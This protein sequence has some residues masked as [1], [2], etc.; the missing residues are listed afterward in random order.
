M[1]LRE[2]F[3]LLGV[4]VDE[5]N[6]GKAEKL[7]KDLNKTA[8]KSSRDFGKVAKAYG[9]ATLK[10]GALAAG[11]AYAG[12]K[13]AQ[14]GADAIETR[15]LIGIAFGEGGDAFIK[16]TEDL[17]RGTNRSKF[18][19]QEFGAVLQDQLVGSLQDMEAAS[20]MT[21]TLLERAVDISSAKNVAL[22]DVLIKIKSGLTGETQ[23]LRSLGI[24]VG[25]DSIEAFAKTLGDKRKI[26]DMDIMSKVMLRQK[27]IMFDT[28]RLAGDAVKTSGALANQMVGLRSATRDAAT[29][30]SANLSPGFNQLTKAIRANVERTTEWLKVN[31]EVI[32]SKFLEYMDHLTDAYKG[33]NTIMGEMVSSLVALSASLGDTESAFLKLATLVGIIALAFWSPIIAIGLLGALLLSIA[34]D[35]QKF[36]DGHKSAIGYILSQYPNAI[37][38]FQTM[39]SLVEFGIDV[40]EWLGL[41][42]VSVFKG[43]FK[44]VDQILLIFK[45]FMNAMMTSYTFITDIFTKGIETAFTSL[46]D[47]ILYMF[48]EL[49]GVDISG[50]VK[51]S[52]RSLGKF[53]GLGKKQ[54]EATFVMD[55]VRPP[56]NVSPAVFARNG[57]GTG[58]RNHVEQ[59][60]TNSISVTAAP[61]EAK[62]VGDA[63]HKRL[64]GGFRMDLDQTMLDF[65]YGE[66]VG[67]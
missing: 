1:I 50:F 57:G 45:F 59:T 40:V 64:S 54:M 39:W 48:D 27:K 28:E 7:L 3:V 35:V 61:G 22:A 51:E 12:V 9:T 11:A 24:E 38:L 53:F 26:R 47:N 16:F 36:E 52:L 2:V 43:M 25:V 5:K 20:T 6:L 37:A 13:F 67:G 55:G 32:T 58:P 34:E 31:N 29:E 60:Q 15:N 30:L 49:F 42:F 66:P 17:S 41:S 65:S 33:V 19:L 44:A 62:Q 18:D 10:L 56:N 14:L 23:A 46:V 8:E 21:E 4:K 63:I